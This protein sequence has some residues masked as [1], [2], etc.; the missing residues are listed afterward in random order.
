MI[1]AGHI[2]QEAASNGIPKESNTRKV[3]GRRSARDARSNRSWG[4]RTKAIMAEG[5]AKLY[6]RHMAYGMELWNGN[7]FSCLK[8]QSS[9]P[10][11]AEA[12]LR[13]SI[14]RSALLNTIVVKG[15]AW[16]MLAKT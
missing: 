9:L 14:S 10:V 8:R 15:I 11:D 6:N 16:V 7:Q 4:A 5:V 3:E 2:F 1:C 13:S 12:M